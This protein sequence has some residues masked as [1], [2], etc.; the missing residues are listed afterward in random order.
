MTTN[1]SSID[2][3]IKTHNPFAGHIVVRP[4]QIWGKSFPDVPSINAHASNS[5]FDAIEKINKGKLQTVGITITAE[6]GLGKSHIISRIRHQLQTRKD[7]LFIYMSKYDNLNQIQNQFLQSVTS[8]LRAFCRPNVMQWQEIAAALINEVTQ[9]KYTPEQ[10]ISSIFPQLLKQYSP[11]V[12]ETLRNRIEQKKPNIIN[13]YII[14]AVLWTLSPAY[15]NYANFW[16]SGS[17]LPEEHAQLM[18]LPNLKTQDREPEIL[19]NVR[20]ILDIISEYRIPVICFDELDIADIADNGFTAAQVI[21]NLAKDL[22]NN[23]QKS[24]LLLAM[25][26][27]TWNQQIRVLPQAEAVI[28]RLVSEQPD[29]QPIALKYLNSDDIV[30]LVQTWLQDFY[31]KHKQIPPHPLYPFE[32]NRLKALGKEKPTVRSVLKWCADNFAPKPNDPPVTPP[33]PIDPNPVKPYFQSELV[34]LKNSIN[35]LLDDEVEISKAL[36]F[37][38]ERLIGQTV[39]GVIIEKIEDIPYDN[40]LDF[41][42]IGN[43]QKIKIGVDVLQTSGGV[44]VNAALSKLINYQKFDLTRGCL[45]R[46]KK[47]APAA[48]AARENLRILLEEK[49]GEWVSLQSQD[50][51]PLLAIFYVWYNRIS[52]E[53]T[54][55][56]IFEFIKQKQLAIKNPLIREIL[57]DPSGQEPTNLTDNGLPISIPQSAGNTE[58]ININL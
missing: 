39:E 15:V 17:E 14:Q 29:R 23:L 21:A 46:S 10:Y 52:Y 12:V 40:H 41:K 44:G 28:D 31:H 38:F 19:S 9:W 56:Q 32:E 11:K 20:Q 42:I 13:P 5:V 25:Y 30:A 48:L 35:S 37:S 50:I 57:S 7:S 36:K 51:K 43:Q 2:E 4:Q 24:V 3:L 55:E 34:H 45:V 22:Y 49:G 8:S 27:D 26:P 53:L 47:I 33:P 58:N 16:L 1:T 54:E 6:K 18:G